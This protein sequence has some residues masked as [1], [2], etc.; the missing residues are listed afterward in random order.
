MRLDEIDQME[1]DQTELIGWIG[2]KMRTDKTDRMIKIKM[3]SDE[4]N[5]MIEIKMR[6]DGTNQIIEIKN[7]IRQ[8]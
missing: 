3:R 7:E 5:Q 1:R 8:D 4:T 6:I 2:I